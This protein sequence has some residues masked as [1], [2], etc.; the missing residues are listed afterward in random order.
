MDK[1]LGE[2]LYI[3]DTDV[4]KEFGVF[5]C[6]EKK[7][8]KD[9][10]T[11]IMTASKTK[12]HV[13]VNIREENGEKHSSKL[14]VAN[15]AR[16]LTLH[17]ALI[18]DTKVLWLKK[19]TSFIKFL[20]GGKYGWLNIRLPELGMTMRVFYEDSPNFKPITCL[21]KE[22]KQAGRFKIKFREPNPI[23]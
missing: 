16:D 2:L 9:N 7:G 19:Y 21:W 18:A 1:I 23:I 13:A 15:E 4:W 8:G 6:E 14:V 10:L 12:A 3:N 22:G 5:L 11:A 20:K 17:F